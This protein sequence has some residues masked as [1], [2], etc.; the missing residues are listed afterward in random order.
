LNEFVGYSLEGKADG[1]NYSQLTTL[2]VKAIQEQQAIIES[3]ATEIETLKTLITELSN[4][5]QI[6]ENN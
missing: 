2:T 1:I 4:R 6:L 3:Q 5:L